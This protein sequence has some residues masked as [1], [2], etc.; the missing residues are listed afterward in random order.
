MEQLINRLASVVWGPVMLALMLGAGLYF[1]LRGRCL[2]VRHWPTIWRRTFGDMIRGGRG[3]SAGITPFQAVSTALASTV[4]TGNIVG[5]AAVLMAGGPGAVFWMWVSAFLG[6]ATKYAEVV[7]AQTYRRPDGRGGFLGGPMYVIRDALGR[8][9]LAGAFAVLGM[10]ASFGV[11]NMIQAGALS[12]AVVELTG[13][14][15]RLVGL[16]AMAVAGAVV[17]GGA[18]LVARVTETLVP[19][20]AGLYILGAL[21]ILAVHIGRVPAALAL[22][23]REAFRPGP[24]AA[25]AGGFLLSRA[26]RTGLARGVFSNEAGLGSAAIAHAA[27]DAKSP[28]EQGFWGAMEVFLDTLVICTLTAL[29]L[30][31]SG[32]YSRWQALVTA[33]AL[34][35]LAEAAGPVSAAADPNAPLA[36]LAFTGTLGPWGGMLLG[37]CTTLFALA[38]I[39]GWSFYGESCCRYLFP[40]WENRAVL[41]YRVVYIVAVYLGSTWSFGLLWGLS[42]VLNGLMAVPNLIALFLL[43]GIVV[44]ATNSYFAEERRQGGAGRRR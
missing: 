34:P 4:G 30:L 5:V 13:A 6:M 33:G 12:Q 28:V 41:C 2:Q 36:L 9:L 31:S 29:A 38:T 26:L 32:V 1:T 23:V 18:R 14:S 35:A 22:I 40:R 24:A 37:I 19:F 21:A 43:S 15:P 44:K 27:A 17:L 8:P 42:D 39:I 7:L 16:L 25:G 11:G 20:M 3:R 10:L